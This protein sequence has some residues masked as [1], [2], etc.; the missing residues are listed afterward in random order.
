MKSYYYNLSGGLNTAITKTELG[1]DTRKICWSDAKNVEVYKNKGIA[2]QNGNVKVFSSLNNVP[3]TGIFGY[4]SGG[5]EVILFNTSDGKV[6][7]KIGS[8]ITLVY[9]SFSAVNNVVYTRFLTGVVISNGVDCPIYY[10]T[11]ASLKVQLCNATDKNGIAIR[12]TAVAAYRGR[13]WIASGST[14]YFTALGTFNDWTTADDAGYMKNFLSDVDKITALQGY[15]D[16]LAIYKA[17]NT[18][19]LSG[20]SPEDFAITKFADK[21]A[22]CQQMVV[23]CNNKQYFF[24]GAIFMLEQVGLLSQIAL[25]SEITLAI[26]DRFDDFDKTATFKGC[27]LNYEIKNQIWLFCPMLDDSYIR[28][29]FIYDYVNDSWTVRNIP[30]PITSAMLMNGTIYTADYNGNVYKEDFGNTFNGVPIE[31]LWKSPFLA[32]GEPNARKCVDDFYFVVDDGFDN[33]FMFSTYKDYDSEV[34]DDAILVTAADTGTLLWDSDDLMWGSDDDNAAFSEGFWIKPI[35][36]VYKSEITQ[37]NYSVQL[38]VH[39]YDATHNFAL[40]GLEFREIF[41][42]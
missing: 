9:S 22:F 35:D 15:K 37:S 2:R 19:L 40:I 39:G 24:N 12:G 26:K 20:T 42:D 36:A 17:D 10:D 8:T 6:Y 16:Y 7:S 29:V 1:L 30:Q 38:A 25:G 13:L 32:L 41:Y 31:F 14:L 23:N 34:A 11:T 4:E 3:V 21:G 18:F 5:V 33:N 28:T 27:M